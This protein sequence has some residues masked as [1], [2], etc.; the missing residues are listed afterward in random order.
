MAQL[1]EDGCVHSAHG[2]KAE[3]D[4]LPGHG[5]L[6]RDR[7]MLDLRRKDGTTPEMDHVISGE[8][9][10]VCRSVQDSL[11]TG[12]LRL[13]STSE[14]VAMNTS[15]ESRVEARPLINAGLGAKE[16]VGL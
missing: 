11:G 5:R 8:S 1:S 15:V 6:S 14:L 12:A 9:R 4:Y 2:N 13:G 10:V 3:I 16:A 7:K